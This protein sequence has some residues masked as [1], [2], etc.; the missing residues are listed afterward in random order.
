[1]TCRLAAA[2]SAR[3]CGILA[4]PF[5]NCKGSAIDGVCGMQAQASGQAAKE[6]AEAYRSALQE[7]TLFKSRTSAALLQVETFGNGR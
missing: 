6:R 7:L 4:K 2:G 3:S 1:M 5:S